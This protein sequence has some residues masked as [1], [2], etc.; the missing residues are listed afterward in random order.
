MLPSAGLSAKSACNSSISYCCARPLWHAVIHSPLESFLLVLEQMSPSNMLVSIVTDVGLLHIRYTLF[1]SFRRIALH[2]CLLAS[3]SH[4]LLVHGNQKLGFLNICCGT[5]DQRLLPKGQLTMT[6]LVRCIYRQA[7]STNAHV[8]HVYYT[9]HVIMRL[10][11]TKVLICYTQA[12]CVGKCLRCEIIMTRLIG[13]VEAFTP[14]ASCMYIIRYQKWAG[15]AP[16]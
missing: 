6:V 12:W 3:A 11:H 10:T 8:I 14:R 4:M 13:E 1:S 2:V 15:L 9:S 7:L 5:H 16:K